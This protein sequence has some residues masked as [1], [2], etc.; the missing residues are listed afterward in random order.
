MSK[1]H[2]YNNYS[3]PANNKSEKTEPEVRT[4]NLK[5]EIP[6]S[7][8]D[9]EVS[10][11]KEESEV[12]LA[13]VMFSGKVVNCNLLNIREQASVDANVVCEINKDDEV[14]INKDESTSDFY[15]VCTATGIEGYCM[16]EFIR[17]R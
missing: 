11:T 3:K 12:V 17:I 4:E 14:I 10:E 13:E 5:D 6:V 8:T 9:T 1:H 15:K 7:E 2:N 16:K